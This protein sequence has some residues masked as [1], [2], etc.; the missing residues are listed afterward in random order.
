MSNQFINFQTN[1]KLFP[2]WILLNFKKYQLPEY[3]QNKDEDPCRMVE[4]KQELRKYQEFLSK[5]LDYK[6]PYREILIYHGLGSGKTVT[7]INIYN[8][9]YNYNPDWNVF[10]LIKASLKKDPWE[11]DLNKWLSSKDKKDRF[12][13][14]KFIHYDSPYADKDFLN[15]VKMSDSSKKTIYIFDETHNFIKNVYNNINSN[16]GQRAYFIYNYIKQHNIACFIIS[17]YFGS[18]YIL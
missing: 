10:I 18:I 12:N 13:N 17:V 14:I 5:Y 3:I 2:S 8:T 6:S 1:G 9:L 4:T 16:I 15:Q 11:K 7:A